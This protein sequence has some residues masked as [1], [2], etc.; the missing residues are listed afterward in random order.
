MGDLKTI[1]KFDTKFKQVLPTFLP[2]TKSFTFLLI[3]IN[4]NFLILPILSPRKPLWT[5]APLALP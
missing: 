4:F 3:F 1:Y 5:V 2:F